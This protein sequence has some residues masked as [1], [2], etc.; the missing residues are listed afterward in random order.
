MG[1]LTLGNV[2]NIVQTTEEQITRIRAC[3]KNKFIRQYHISR[4]FIIPGRLQLNCLTNKQINVHNNNL[5]MWVWYYIQCIN[6]SDLQICS[7]WKLQAT[8]VYRYIH[9]QLDQHRVSKQSLLDKQVKRMITITRVLLNFNGYTI[10]RN[11]P[12]PV[13]DNRNRPRL[14]CFKWF[15]LFI[16]SF[17]VIKHQQ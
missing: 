10:N 1:R 11:P 17:N 16:F 12:E 7:P 9:V 15:K 4:S 6:T 5:N 2:P 3:Q 13:S 8:L 14:S